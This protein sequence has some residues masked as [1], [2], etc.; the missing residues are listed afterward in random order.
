MPPA[1][2]QPNWDAERRRQRRQQRRERRSTARR[3]D[4]T[5]RVAP[6]QL[7][8]RKARQAAVQSPT[9]KLDADTEYAIVRWDLV[10]LT[11][12]SV[13]CFAV[14]VVVLVVVGM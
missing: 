1:H 12:Y 8:P 6:L 13:A 7:D 10:R 2:R 5:P 14:M 11:M 3:G 4:E 9:M